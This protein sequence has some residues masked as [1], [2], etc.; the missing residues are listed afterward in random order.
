M[1]ATS[2]TSQIRFPET[3]EGSPKK[4]KA[5]LRLRMRVFRFSVFAWGRVA[6]M[7]RRVFSRTGSG[8]LGR[9]RDARA[10]A[11]SVL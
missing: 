5:F 6:R 8:M 7:R 10:L 3:R 1:V 2:S 11:R 4:A 9:R